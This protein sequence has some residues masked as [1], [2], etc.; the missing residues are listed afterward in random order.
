MTGQVR[1]PTIYGPGCMGLTPE[2]WALR[3]R[4]KT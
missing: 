3:E 4:A 1:R 2:L